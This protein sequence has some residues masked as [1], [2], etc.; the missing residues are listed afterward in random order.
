MHCPIS[1]IFITAY[2]SIFAILPC[3]QFIPSPLFRRSHGK[4]SLA[5]IFFPPDIGISDKRCI[6]PRSIPAQNKKCLPHRRRRF[7]LARSF[8]RRRF[9][10]AK[11]RA[12]RHLGQRRKSSPRLLA[13]KRQ[14]APQTF[15]ALFVERCRRQRPNFWQSNSWQLRSRHQRPGLLLPRLQ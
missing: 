4:E 15:T 1:S 6:S 5:P 12:R 13:R 7:P 9:F 14:R 11:F 3:L 10:P 2:S 8:H